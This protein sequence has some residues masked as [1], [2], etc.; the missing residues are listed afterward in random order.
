MKKI[1]PAIYLLMIS[2]GSLAQLE[3]KEIA[4]WEVIGK[5]QFGGIT[6]AKMQYT[7][8]GADTTYML[9]VKDAGEQDR[10]KY[11]SVVFKGINGTYEKLYTILKSFFLPE[12]KKNKKYIR[13]F[14]LGDTGVSVQHYRLIDGR[15]VMFY[16]RD[17]YAYWTERDIDK[18]FGKR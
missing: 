6:K 7:L 18:L 15:A 5:L 13:A 12:N 8:S 9:L 1:I 14:D 4:G 3:E 16:T 17:G 10:K 2:L 11:F